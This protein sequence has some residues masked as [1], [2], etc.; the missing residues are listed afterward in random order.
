MQWKQ[1]LKTTGDWQ[2]ATG[3]RPQRGARARHPTHHTR[4]PMPDARRL[5]PVA[6]E[7][8]LLYY[9]DFE[10]YPIFA[11]NF[12]LKIMSNLLIISSFN[13]KL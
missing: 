7:F 12:S 8:I 10:K 9:G 11:T 13:L 5:T 2:Q 6:H 4:G 3:C 1:G